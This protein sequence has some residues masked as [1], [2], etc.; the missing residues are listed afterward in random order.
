MFKKLEKYRCWVTVESGRLM[1]CK[2]TE[3]GSP[4]WFAG[5]MSWVE[6]RSPIDEEF[7]IAANRELGTNFTCEN[8]GAGSF[9]R[10]PPEK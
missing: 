3:D 5:Q 4:E 1:Q 6:V 8:L 2:I 7:L 10:F 9:K